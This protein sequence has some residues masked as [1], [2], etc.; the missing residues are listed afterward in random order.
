MKIIVI[1]GVLILSLLTGCVPSDPTF[2]LQQGKFVRKTMCDGRKNWDD[3]YKNANLSC[4]KGYTI[5]KK[6]SGHVN[7]GQGA[8]GALVWEGLYKMTYGYENHILY[9]VCKK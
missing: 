7:M 1:G 6:D 5:T 9:F 2:D 4:S 3:C 8:L